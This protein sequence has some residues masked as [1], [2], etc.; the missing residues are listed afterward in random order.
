M[1]SEAVERP[2]TLFANDPVTIVAL[3]RE[4]ANDLLRHW[5]NPLWIYRYGTSNG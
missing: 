2:L 5:D 3:D 1:R 4:E